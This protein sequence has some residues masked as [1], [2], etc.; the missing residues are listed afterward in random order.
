VTEKGEGQL[1]ERRVKYEVE[2]LWIGNSSPINGGHREN[3]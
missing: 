3:K 2:A 1:T